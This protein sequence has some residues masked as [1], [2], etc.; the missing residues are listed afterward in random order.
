MRPIL[1]HPFVEDILPVDGGAAIPAPPAK[2]AHKAANW[3]PAQLMKDLAGCD[4][5]TGIYAKA[6]AANSGKDPIIRSGHSVIG[7]G[8]S[9]NE[10][11]G[12]ITL[13]PNQSR[14]QA[15]QIAIFEL[16]NL[17]NKARFA[18]VDAN[19]AAGKIGREQYT[20]ANEAIEY[21]GIANASQAFHACG[22]RWGAPKG[23]AGFYDFFAQ[24]KNFDDYYK[25][26]LNLDHKEFYR[27]FWD[28]NYKALYNAAHPPHKHP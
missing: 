24:A 20:R 10:D 17:S 18:K 26:Y 12:V 27:R 21:Q 8:G 4:G 19:V 23:V 11:T 25:N 7:S 14:A 1:R 16:T 13:D 15:A 5:G 6:K 28:K 3:S 2:A 9:T 22:N